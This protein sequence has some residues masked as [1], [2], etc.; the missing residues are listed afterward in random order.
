MYN[1]G[2]TTPFTCVGTLWLITNNIHF[3]CF[4]FTYCS[5]TSHLHSQFAY[6]RGRNAVAQISFAKIS[7]DFPGNQHAPLKL[8]IFQKNL[9]LPFYK[10]DINHLQTLLLLF[11]LLFKEIFI[12]K[13]HFSLIQLE[14]PA[15]KVTNLT[16]VLTKN[17]LSNLRCLQT[18][19]SPYPNSNQTTARESGFF[20]KLTSLSPSPLPR[21]TPYLRS[22]N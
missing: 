3:T 5:S 16:R 11:S 2:Q 4:C 10:R 7:E 20:K 8:K 21:P 13:R 17:V 22:T 19:F 18:F 6:Y 12:Q 15:T 9:A 1:F 14:K